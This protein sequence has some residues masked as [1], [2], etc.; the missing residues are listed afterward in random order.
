MPLNWSLM[1][2]GAVARLVAMPLR[3]QTVPRSIPSSGAFFSKENTS[4]AVLS[5]LLI[6]EEQLSVDG[7]KM[8]AKYW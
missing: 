2:K 3:M 6:E 5:L 7:E 8:C 1:K 4:T